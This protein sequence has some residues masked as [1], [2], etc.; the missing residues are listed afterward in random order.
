MALFAGL[1]IRESEPEPPVEMNPE[2]PTSEANDDGN[3]VIIYKVP[4]DKP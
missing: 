4:S 3:V 1:V 2:N